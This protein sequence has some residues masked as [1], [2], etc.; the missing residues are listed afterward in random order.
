M[1]KE[2][3]RRLLCDLLEPACTGRLSDELQNIVLV[4]F[5]TSSCG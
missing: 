5:R 4:Q 2:V 1:I 3:W